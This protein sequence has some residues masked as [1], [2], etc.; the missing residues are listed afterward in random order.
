MTGPPNRS[1]GVEETKDGHHMDRLEEL[2]KAIAENTVPGGSAFGRA[3]AEMILLTVQRDGDDTTE[4]RELT[5]WLVATKPSMTSV[6]TVARLAL[7]A[8]AAGNGAR[9][10]SEMKGFIRDSE[11]A[12]ES[13]AL[14][15]DAHIGSGARVLFH[16]FSGSLIQLLTRAAERTP[17][18]TLLFTESR[19]YRESRRIVA[20]LS[21]YPLDF[22]GYSDAAVA[23]AASAADLAVVGVD[24]L[25]A[26]GSFA[27][28]TGTLP[29]AL[30]CDHVG[31]PLYAVTEVSKL[32]AGDPADVAMEQ[33][34]AEEME[35]GWELAVSKRVTMRNQFFEI[36]PASLVTA[37]WTD[38][39][40]LRPTE[41]SG[42]TDRGTRVR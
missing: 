6:R 5:D 18:L 1:A 15:A 11:A 31:I 13:V 9:V 4:L 35:D 25:F 26:D 20:A 8:A 2:R 10:I 19:P 17:H 42:V 36:T 39:G 16:S 24:A 41:I 12:I 30:A 21:D 37:Y 3:A 27:N 23:V 7:D 34:P 29:L 32:Y 14:H 40:V 38:I 28:K 22:E 33:R